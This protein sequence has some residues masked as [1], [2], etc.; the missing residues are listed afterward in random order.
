M[1][2]VVDCS[3]ALLSKLPLSFDLSSAEQ[4]YTQFDCLSCKYDTCE[5]SLQACYKDFCQSA[6]KRYSVIA[7]IT[8]AAA[9]HVVEAS[10]HYIFNSYVNRFV[11]IL[12]RSFKRML[13]CLVGIFAMLI[14]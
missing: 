9:I 12:C 5:C 7:S 13:L 8:F 11:V 2:H 4:T 1:C 10:L 14:P 6:Y 3:V